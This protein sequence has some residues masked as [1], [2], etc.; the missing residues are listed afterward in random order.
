[1]TTEG[2]PSLPKWIKDA[3][4]PLERYLCE[5]STHEFLTLQQATE[6]IGEA[7]TDFSDADIDHALD[8]LL[9]RGWLYKVDDQLFITELQCGEST[10]SN[11]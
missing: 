9:N 5:Q 10:E 3:Y 4:I 7:N 1:M 6:I 11:N 2:H 8:Y